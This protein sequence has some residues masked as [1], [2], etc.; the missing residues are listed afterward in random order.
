M[1]FDLDAFILNRAYL[2]LRLAAPE[3]A[4]IIKILT[5]RRHWR[6]Q[7]Q[8]QHLGIHYLMLGEA[9]YKAKIM[10]KNIL[11]VLNGKHKF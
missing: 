1:I 5:F 7:W 2:H 9:L 11:T 6:P 4:R 10:M 3:Q 8:A